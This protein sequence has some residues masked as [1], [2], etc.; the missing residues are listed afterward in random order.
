MTLVD[1]YMGILYRA[2]MTSEH[3]PLT[4]MTMKEEASSQLSKTKPLFKGT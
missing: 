2:Q 3:G 1:S 4:H